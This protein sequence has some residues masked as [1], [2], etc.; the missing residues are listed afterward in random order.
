MILVSYV[1][2]ILFAGPYQK[3]LL[4]MAQW[5]ESRFEIR[6]E[7][8]MNIYLG[9]MT[10]LDPDQLNLSIHNFTM[11][12]RLLRKFR[13]NDYKPS[14]TPTQKGIFSDDGTGDPNGEQWPYL[15]LVGI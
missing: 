14:G 9:I 3:K 13:M 12:D 15:E 10:E 4:K 1:D 8:V 7:P 11:I 2:D 6:I 5:I